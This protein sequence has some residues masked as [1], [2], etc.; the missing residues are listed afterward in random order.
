MEEQSVNEARWLLV[1]V[2]VFCVGFGFLG[3]MLA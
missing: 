2:F 3:M 1:P